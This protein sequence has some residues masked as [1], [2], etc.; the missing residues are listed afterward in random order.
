ML[1]EELTEILLHGVVN[2]YISESQDC[3]L[4]DI[5]E[6]GEWYIYWQLVQLRKQ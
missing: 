6:H 1:F 2:R 3:N 4:S 5:S